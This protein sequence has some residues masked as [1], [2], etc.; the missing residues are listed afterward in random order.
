MVIFV[1]QLLLG[2]KPVLFQIGCTARSIPFCWLHRC[3]PKSCTL[4]SPAALVN[5]EQPKRGGHPGIQVSDL[6]RAARYV[7]VKPLGNST[8]NCSPGGL[9]VDFHLPFCY[10][11]AVDKGTRQEGDMVSG[12]TWSLMRIWGTGTM[13]D[14]YDAPV[15]GSVPVRTLQHEQCSPQENCLTE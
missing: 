8:E 13:W 1:T 9:V 10:Q 7:P 3:Q 14:R 11:T 5:L 15:L 6:S 12:C 2:S 4:C